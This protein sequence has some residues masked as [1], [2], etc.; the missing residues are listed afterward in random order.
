MYLCDSAADATFHNTQ[1]EDFDTCIC[2]IM[3]TVL[4]ENFSAAQSIVLTT[5]LEHLSIV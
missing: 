1:F 2:H 3:V 4:L 5:L